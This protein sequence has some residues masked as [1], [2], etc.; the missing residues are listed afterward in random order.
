MYNRLSRNGEVRARL[1]CLKELDIGPNSRVLEVSVGTG[2]N[3]RLLPADARYV[4]LDISLGMLKKCRSNLQRW[5]QQAD[6]FQGAAETL[7]FSDNSFDVVYHIGGINSFNDKAKAIREMIRVAKPGSKILIVD[8]T[9]K[10]AR[11][12]HIIPPTAL[13]PSEMREKTFEDFR[14]GRLY[15]LT[16]RKP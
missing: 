10:Y 9:G 2:A 7:P 11:S 13:I 4:G 14:D 8:E 15:R 1:E 3:L 6:L 5:K 12:K 16:F